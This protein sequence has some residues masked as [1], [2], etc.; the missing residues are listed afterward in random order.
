MIRRGVLGDEEHLAVVH[1][2]S[3][4]IAYKDIFPSEFLENLDLDRRRDWWR[5]FLARGEWVAVA[6]ADEVVGFCTASLSSEDESWGEVHTIYVDPDHWGEGHGRRLLRAGEGHLRD[7]GAKRALLW[8]LE[9]NQRARSFYERE[10]WT[11]GGPF[12]IEDIA[13]NQV[14]EVRYVTALRE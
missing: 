11:V 13:G 2:R 5:A 4:Q 12:R 6:V 7:L 14:S 10:G 3:W 9:D 1:V 8:V